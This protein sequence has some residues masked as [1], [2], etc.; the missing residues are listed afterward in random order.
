MKTPLNDHIEKAL[1]EIIFNG[2][3]IPSSIMR[4][5]F[6]TAVLLAKLE[7]NQEHVANMFKPIDIIGNL[8]EPEEFTEKTC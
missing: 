4:T 5:Y 2:C 6:D 7:A 3:K 1:S 8:H